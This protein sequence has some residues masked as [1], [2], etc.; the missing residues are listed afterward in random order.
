VTVYETR[1]LSGIELWRGISHGATLFHLRDSKAEYFQ[2]LRDFLVRLH[3]GAAVADDERETIALQRASGFTRAV[4]CGGEALHPSLAS[5]LRST[6]LPFSIEIDTAGIYAAKRGAIR[7]FDAMAWQHGVALDMGQSHLK[8]ITR[9]GNAC[10]ARD[11]EQLPFGAHSID[12]SEGRARIRNFIEQGLAET[13]AP[14]G[15]VLGLPVAIGGDG[16][17]EPATYP[18]LFGD[19]NPIFEGLFACPWVVL[20][21]AVLAAV[22]F[23]P[24]PREK[25]L[26]VTLGFGIGGALWES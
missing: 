20:N 24:T 12:A 8:V 10:V 23:E 11:V 1:G 7:I 17:A 22:G 26:V 5:T 6:P 2:A 19:I 9:E 13:K 16:I 18:G 25:T 21:D 3:D 4:L 15:V 14:D